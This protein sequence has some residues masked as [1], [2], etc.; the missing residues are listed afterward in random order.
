LSSFAHFGS[1]FAKFGTLVCLLYYS[2]TVKSA[3]RFAYATWF[4]GLDGKAFCGERRLR[5]YAAAKHLN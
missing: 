4:S 1:S 5:A 2:D 3:S